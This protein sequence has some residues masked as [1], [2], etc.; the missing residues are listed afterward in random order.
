MAKDPAFLLYSSDFLVGTARM[1]EAEVGQ[2]IRLICHIHTGGHMDSQDMRT[3][4][5]N[6]SKKVMAKFIKDSDGLYF[7]ERLESEI[8]KRKAFTSSRV[9]NLRGHMAQHMDVHMENENENEDVNTDEDEKK[10]VRRKFVKP[11]LDEVAAYFEQIEY[12][13][14][15]IAQKFVDYNE[16]K[17]WVVGK[18]PMKD[19]KAACRTWKSNGFDKAKTSRFDEVSE[20][21][22]RMGKD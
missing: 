21:F 3:I 22:L 14:P 1:T 19:W 13:P 6:L 18:A 11:T 9:K 2:Y 8:I 15:G 5:P 7:N 16:S 20:K 10:I 12:S 4:C 17:G